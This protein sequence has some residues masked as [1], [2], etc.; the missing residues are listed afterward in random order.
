[1]DSREVHLMLHQAQYLLDDSVQ[2]GWL[3]IHGGS[4]RESQKILD[5]VPAAPAFGRDQVKGIADLLPPALTLISMIE[6]LPQQLCVGQ[7]SRQRIV[8]LVSQHRGH[9]P[10]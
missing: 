4:A 2:I 9:L 6:I 3:D 8:D 10:D 1:M 5:Q 7:N